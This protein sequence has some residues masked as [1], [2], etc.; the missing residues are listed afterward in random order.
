MLNEI[1]EY[2]E[3]TYDLDKTACAPKRIKYN[4]LTKG[5]NGESSGIGCGIE[6]ILSIIARHFL[7]DFNA[8]GALANE[9]AAECAILAWLGSEPYEK[10]QSEK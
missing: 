7:F 8:L 3:Y 4:V 5:L 6:S 9:D 10:K 1:R 2:E